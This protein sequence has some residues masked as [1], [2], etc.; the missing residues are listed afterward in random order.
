MRTKFTLT[1][2]LLLTTLPVLFAQYWESTGAL[3]GAGS[4]TYLTGATHVG[5]TIFV[6]SMEQSLAYSTNQGTTWTKQTAAKP[7]GT[8]AAIT[9]AKDRLYASFKVNTY[10][11][12]LY[13]S[14][15]NGAT[16]TIDTVGLPKNLTQTGKSGMILKYMGNDYILAHN[17]SKSVYKKLGDPGWKSTFI[18]NIIVD[19]SATS[20]KWL[21]IGQAKMLQ[22]TNH[23]ESWT[24]LGT[25][26][27]P[28]NF[29]GSL[30]CSNGSRIYVSNPPADGA[31]DI[32]FSDDG[33]SSWTLTNSS[34][35]FSISNPW[36]Q[37]MYAVD[38][39][40]FAAIKPASFIDAPPFI[41]SSTEQ[42]DFSVGDVSGLPTN[43]TNTN[44]PFFFHVGNKLFTMFWDLYSS[45]PGFEGET[46]TT[47][48]NVNKVNS[49]AISVYPNP[50]AQT[51]KLQTNNIEVSGIEIYSLT[52][53]KMAVQNI[54]QNNS[55]NVSSWGSGV[56][57]IKATST[58]G[59]TFQSKFIKQ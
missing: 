56:Y 41:I 47:A 1:I 52:G 8:I 30:I 59:Q 19:I 16:W 22:S 13:Y 20:D 42:P 32:Y 33:G 29:Q 9:G 14:M 5:E 53:Q 51:I 18:D 55:I 2:L 15:D 44:L 49:N 37:N 38:D 23:G 57:L 34:G 39:Y 46:S 10:D 17:Y 54:I 36:I 50:A 11:Y 24:T 35:N 48:I 4:S 12:E 58:N 31:Q 27:L 3:A 6:V 43:K 26:G 7:S 21:A 45:E 40:L 28:D 25:G